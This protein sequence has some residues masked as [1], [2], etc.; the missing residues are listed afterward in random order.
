MLRSRLILVASIPWLVFA[1]GLRAQWTVSLDAGVAPGGEMPPTVGVRA[2]RD[3]ASPVGLEVAAR[4]APQ[5]LAFGAL[6]GP[7][8]VQMAHAFALGGGIHLV[9][10]VGG[11]FIGVFGVGGIAALAP[12]VAG[13][14]GLVALPR[15]AG[16]GY[17]VDLTYRTLWGAS[18]GYLELS[19]GLV[20]R[21]GGAAGHGD[22]TSYVSDM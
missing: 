6:A 4:V 16:R 11:T 19:M 21:R 3:W 14:V 18:E 22:P 1:P 7:V 10:R 17:R 20:W 5:F 9:P 15:D 13:G 12:G 8:D 2:G